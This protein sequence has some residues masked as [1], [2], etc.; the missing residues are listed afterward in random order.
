MWEIRAAQSLE[1][2]TNEY[3]LR[4]LYETLPLS[5]SKSLTECSECDLFRGL[6]G[7]RDIISYIH[8]TRDISPWSPQ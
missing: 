1:P 2:A 5:C 4:R 3:L 7:Y 8:H 6:A